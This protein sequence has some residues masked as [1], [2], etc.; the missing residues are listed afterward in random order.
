MQ[1]MSYIRDMASSAYHKLPEVVQ[2]TISKVDVPKI[3]IPIGATVALSG[4]QAIPIAGLYLVT[5]SASQTAGSFLLPDS[6]V[7]NFMKGGLNIGAAC[8]TGQCFVGGGFVYQAVSHTASY[9]ASE[10]VNQLVEKGLEKLQ[11][12]GRWTKMLTKSTASLFTSFVT[13]KAVQM[14][15][16]PNFSGDQKLVAEK[17]QT[18]PAP[19]P[20]RVEQTVAGGDAAQPTTQSEAGVNLFCL[21]GP[22]D[23]QQWN[24]TVSSGSQASEATKQ[25]IGCLD[26]HDGRT[27]DLQVPEHLGEAATKDHILA[28]FAKETPECSLHKGTTDK[29][30]H[31]FGLLCDKKQIQDVHVCVT[32][33]GVQCGKPTVLSYVVERKCHYDLDNKVSLTKQQKGLKS[34]LEKNG[35]PDVVVSDPEGSPEAW[36]R[37]LEQVNSNCFDGSSANKV[38]KNKG[39]TQGPLRH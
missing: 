22:D 27:I 39:T 35:N 18:K 21:T 12:T 2:N 13:T 7:G 25:Y 16:E 23:P 26:K 8:L 32:K 3:A 9:V 30:G 20:E 34:C 11:F 28:Q 19:K 31:P 14:V 33:N 17:Q 24:C 36:H 4:P 10:G 37:D 1:G 5:S 6:T 15:V 38:P 29:V